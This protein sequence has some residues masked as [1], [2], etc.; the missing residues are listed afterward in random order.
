MKVVFAIFVLFFVA[1]ISC[2]LTRTPFGDV[3]KECVHF[4]GENDVVEHTDTLLIIHRYN[5]DELINSE[6]HKPCYEFQRMQD[7]LAAPEPNGWAAY[8]EDL[9]NKNF[10]S[11]GGV[12]TVPNKPQQDG[13]QTLFLFTGFQNSMGFEDVGVSI[14]QPVLQWGQSEAGGGEY[15]AIAS[16]F[17]GAGNAVYSTL[18]KCTPGD[19][20]VGNM[21]LDTDNNKWE[22]VALDQDNNLKSSIN[23]L[24]GVNE[25][26]AFVTLEVYG[27]STCADYPNGNDQFYDLT[28]SQNGTPFVAAWKPETETGCDESVQIVSSSTINIKF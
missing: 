27:V 3:P 12:W 2:S 6:T 20:I 18:E 16:W 28:L 17:V 21:T 26:D 5:G 4:V 23:V 10:D 7:R 25:V 11:F 22:I 8:A 24:T 15:W 19:V 13:L 14:I 9:T 1:S